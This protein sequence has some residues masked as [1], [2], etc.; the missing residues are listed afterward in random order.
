MTEIS[1][2]F[3]TKQIQEEQADKKTDEV[4][5]WT[6]IS[7]ISKTKKYLFSDDTSKA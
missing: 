4:H 5:V 3:G 6:F 1:T 7:D 2:L